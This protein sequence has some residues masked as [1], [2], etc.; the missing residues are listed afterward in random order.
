MLKK[1]P[2]ES[3]PVLIGITGHVHQDFTKKGIEAGMTEVLSKPCYVD[4]IVK[5]LIKYGVIE[6]WTLL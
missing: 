5:V 4:N 2:K 3:Q 1:E 6:E